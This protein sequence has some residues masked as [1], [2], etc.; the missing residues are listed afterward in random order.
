MYAP[1]V[2]EVVDKRGDVL[3]R[4]ARRLPVGSTVHTRNVCY[5]KKKEKTSLQ[6]LSLFIS[7]MEA[8]VSH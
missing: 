6:P 7:L 5:L 3:A 2:I 1:E 4:F 8:G